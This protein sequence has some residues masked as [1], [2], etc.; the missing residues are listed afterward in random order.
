MKCGLVTEVKPSGV[1]LVLSVLLAAAALSGCASAPAVRTLADGGAGTIR[2]ES[3]TMT[4]GAFLGGAAGRTPVVISGDLRF[5]KGAV[6]RVPAMV[7]V[8]GSDGITAGEEGWADVLVRMGVGA[9][10][11]DS[12]T[13][14]GIRETFS[15][16]SRINTLVMVADAY[17]ALELLAT[18]PR[19]DPSRI[20]LMGLSKGGWVTLYASLKRFQRM[21]GPRALEFAVYLPFYPG[22]NNRFIGDDD[23]THRP[24]RIFNGEA[25]DQSLFATCRDFAER[26]RL[27]GRDVRITAIPG[28][29][30]AFD[31][32]R[33]GAP[34]TDLRRQN[35]SPCA[36]DE[37]S[38]RADLS[39]YIAGCRSQGV[40]AGYDPAGHATAVREVRAL[41][42][43][44]FNLTR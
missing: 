2:F 24:I 11:L 33:A 3:A 9:F 28:A 31:N 6:E 8:H 32:P 39:A 5:P 10:L 37:A 44:A 36:F 19:I 23:V 16:Q 17:R 12:F 4:A 13:G 25:D 35:Y 34:R 41:L 14:R 26:L 27:A 30:H 18:H 22:C 40:T 21:H 15:D 7:I 43:S 42:R 29:Y 38:P 1:S 20:G